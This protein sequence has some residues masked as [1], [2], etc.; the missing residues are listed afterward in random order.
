MIV[1]SKDV[2]RL[3]NVSRSTV[4][5]ALS[6]SVGVSDE[7]R[8]RV[9]AAVEAS[10][11]EPDMIAQSLVKQRSRNISLTFFD[12]GDGV[13]LSLLKES[14]RY[15]YL[16][17]LARIEQET[18]AMSYDLLL[19]SL[20]RKQPEDYVRDLERRRVAGVIMVAP[21]SSDK[22]VQA[23]IKSD[24]PAVFIDTMASGKRAT[25]VKADNIG[26][27][28][29][30]VE[31]LLA[32]GHRR[33]A[34]LTGYMNSLSGTE[35]LLGA[36]QALAGAGVALDPQLICSTGFEREES[37]QAVCDL[38]EKRRDF[39]ALVA[40]SDI[41]AFSALRA[42]HERGIRVPEDVSVVGFDDIDF[43]L[44]VYP[45]L[46]TV[47]PDREV[48]GQKAVH[49]LLNIIN[50]AVDLAPLVAPTQLVVRASTGPAPLL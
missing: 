1:T 28:R 25:Y 12:K 40:P 22:R 30:A 19:L 38:L 11:Y 49:H 39:T 24:I 41:V 50:G 5:R 15:F 47:R 48:M 8:A 3:A 36:Q 44:D 42:L 21:L 10:G 13:E 43:C 33:I 6:G 45:Q 18:F 32:L 31:H 34:I 4:S 37:Y 23:V 29:R 17:I 7:V 26:G 35:R 2:A 20:T 14:K 46:T 9:L 16:D 27:T